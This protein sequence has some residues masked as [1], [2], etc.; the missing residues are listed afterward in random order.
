MATRSRFLPLALVLFVATPI[1]AAPIPGAKP[2]ETPATK[3]RKAL[4]GA[5][6]FRVDGSLADLARFVKERFKVHVTID[7]NALAMT[8]MQPDMAPVQVNLKGARLRDGLKAALAP[9]NLRFGVVNDGLFVSTEE[10]LL[11]RQMRQIVDL[12]GGDRPLTAVLQGLAEQTGANVV[13]D[14]RIAKKGGDATVPLRLDDV[15]L[16]TAVRLA[17]EVAGF[18][19]V[20]MNN[21]LFVTSEERAKVLREDADGPTPTL[22]NFPFGPGLFGGIGAGGA[23]VDVPALP[24][25]PPPPPVEEKKAEKKEEKKPGGP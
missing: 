7:Q 23:V 11:H 18:R 13:L 15:P 19:A 21:V 14:P 4:D 22:P 10:G 17:A 20:R 8:G 16:E 12:D 9:L 1:A 6:D 3:A 2:E 24:P 5:A 25:P